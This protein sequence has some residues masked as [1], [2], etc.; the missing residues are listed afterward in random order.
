MQSSLLLVVSNQ[1]GPA[2]PTL[3]KPDAAKIEFV[4]L[5]GW[6]VFF[7]V[8]SVFFAVSW[9][10]FKQMML[11]LSIQALAQVKPRS[12]NAVG[13]QPSLSEVEALDGRW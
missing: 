8:W 10:I 12:F 4:I 1:Q 7:A 13:S 3:S 9:E 6:L 11:V 5:A 2:N